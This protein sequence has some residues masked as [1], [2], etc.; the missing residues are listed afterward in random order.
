MSFERGVGVR[1]QGETIA[2]PAPQAGSPRHATAAV[3]R[4]LG[5][6]ILGRLASSRPSDG[7][8]VG[9]SGA[10]EGLHDEMAR[11]AAA[12]GDLRG[13]QRERTTTAGAMWIAPATDPSE[14][15]A[16]EV[17]EGVARSLGAPVRVTSVPARVPLLQRSPAAGP[18]RVLPAA[19][20]AEG[21]LVEAGLERRILA[22]SGGGSRLE[23]TVRRPLERAFGADLGHLRIHSGAEA[24]SLSRALRARAFTVGSDIFFR[25][26]AYAPGSEAGRRLLAHEVTHS[27][28]QRAPAAGSRG[29]AVQRTYEALDEAAKASVDAQADR[30]YAQKAEEFE[31]KLGLDLTQVF[32]VNEITDELL[33]RV[34]RIVDAWAVATKQELSAT[35]EREF[36]FEEGDKYY[37]AFVMTGDAIQKV[38]AH[39]GGGKDQPLR[40]RLKVVYNAVRNN[41]L[42]KWLKVASDIVRAPGESVHVLRAAG[43]GLLPNGLVNEVGATRETVDVSFA[44]DSGLSGVLDDDKALLARIAAASDAEK[45]DV[46]HKRTHISGPDMWS[47]IARG[48]PEE[49]AKLDLANRDRVL[50]K[51]SGVDLEDQET[52][53]IGDVADLTAH[54]IQLLRQ[55]K[56]EGDGPVG[57]LR[58]RLYKANTREKLMWEQG[59]EAYTVLLN[60]SFERAAAEIGARLEA[61]LSGSAS[62][63]FTAAKNLGITQVQEL[64]KLRLAMLAWMLPN[65]DHSY[66]EIMTAADVQ[67]VPFA[68]RPGERGSQYEEERNYSP[69]YY[70]RFQ[71]LL[72]E[73]VFPGYFLSMAHKD[74][75]AQAVTGERAEAKNKAQEDKH[76]QAS[77]RKRAIERGLEGEVADGLDVRHLA[78]F[79][80]L[81]DAVRGL[82]LKAEVGDEP[83]Q[84]KIRITNRLA[85]DRLRQGPAYLFLAHRQPIRAELWLGK[86]LIFEK[87]PAPPEFTSLVR[88]MGVMQAGALAADP[89]E[90]R[91]FLLQD[92]SAPVPEGAL[93]GLPDH[94][95]DLLVQF[96]ALVAGLN[97]NKGAGIESDANRDEYSRYL[98]SPI[99]RSLRHPVPQMSMNVIAERFFRAY[100]GALVAASIGRTSASSTSRAVA[101]GVPDMLARITSEEMLAEI[102]QVGEEIAMLP[103]DAPADA[104]L[105][106]CLGEHKKIGQ[107]FDSLHGTNRF[108]MVVVA[109]AQKVGVRFEDVTLRTQALAASMYHSEEFPSPGPEEANYSIDDANKFDNPNK[110]QMQAV[111]GAHGLT[112]LEICAINDYTTEEAGGGAWQ[113]ALESLGDD[114]AR[115]FV[116]RMRAAVSGLRK[117]PCYERPVYSGQSEYFKGKAN[118]AMLH[119]RLGTVHDFK[120]FVSASKESDSSFISDDR[121][122]LAWV[123]ERPRTGRDITALSTKPHEKEVLFPPGA[124]FMVTRV[125]DHSNQAGPPYYA[126]VWIWFDEL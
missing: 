83:A 39:L 85:I 2:D 124:R 12:R 75:L 63:M 118:L 93:I 79:I 59:R 20:G 7:P 11:M 115:R 102:V 30:D 31:Y 48:T 45:R 65:H 3:G 38:F 9:P 62:M 46:D 110:K 60:S 21:G 69:V 87:K 14:R 29:L 98:D 27:F 120:N 55:R 113:A 91:Q 28:Q 25:Q 106:K 67:G 80:A 89:A 49:I 97:L 5:N 53:R 76:T 117:L 54:E 4:G 33:A 104:E 77:Y 16:D 42:A 8:Q 100:H 43:R 84:K 47:G 119:Y 61:G 35:Y 86:I 88:G 34:K 44:K 57:A 56:G 103:R 24:D 81:S 112:L 64:Q 41:N 95:I 105:R 17:A 78:E 111:K 107:E 70:G 22:A 13:S 122:G 108:S 90:R 101:L 96:K 6:R 40:K 36:A 32:A 126:K 15:E 125:E 18:S 116:P 52:L 71:R 66:Y 37:G 123:I 51:N 72:P 92:D 99:W 23:H 114:A 94:I 121:V 109:M 73:Q 1:E 26:G 58:K 50:G 10:R 82:E 74:K 68:F 19:L